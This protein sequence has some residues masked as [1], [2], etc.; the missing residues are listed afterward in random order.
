MTKNW[1]KI[2]LSE[3]IKISHGWAFKGKHFSEETNEDLPIVVS[4]GNFRYDGGFRFEQTKIKRYVG[5]YPEEYELSPGDILLIMTCQTAGGEILGV[6]GKVPDNNNTYLHNQR[7]GKVVNKKPREVSNEYLYWLFLSH[8]F[9]NH[10]YSTSTGTKILHTSP[11]KIESFNFSLPPL[12]EQKRIAHVLGTL[13]DKIELNRQMNQTLE[14]MAQAI[15]K[16]WFVDFDG[17]DEFVESE[18]GPIPKGWQ[19]LPV[20]KVVK[21]VGGS[22]PSTK[23]PE[24]WDDGDINWTTP[25]DLSS[26]EAP[27]LLETSRKITQAGVDSISSGLLPVGTLLMSSRAPVGYLAITA[28]PTAINQGYIAMLPGGKLSSLYLLHWAK[29]NMDVIKSRAGGTTFAEISKRNFRPIPVIVP[30]QK[31]LASFEK[32]AEP[33]FQKIQLNLEQSRTLTEL[34]DTLLPKLISGELRVPEALE[35][36]EDAVGD[37][38][39]GDQSVSQLGLPFS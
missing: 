36:A 21:S 8:S 30:D 32:T 12:E 13:D 17:Q 31:T 26:A 24:Y 37:E 1:K 14:E 39:S 27:I 9:N 20:S 28:I 6:P 25:K 35:V 29:F 18:L 38:V 2:Q 5:T 33:I 11:S 22:T 4:I 7:L 19:V 23:K 34:R 16:S 15:F 3:I 10:L